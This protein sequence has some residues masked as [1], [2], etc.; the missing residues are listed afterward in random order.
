VMHLRAS[1]DQGRDRGD[2]DAVAEIAHFVTAT[3]ALASPNA[4]P[5]SDRLS[6]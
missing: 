6:L 3:P 1:R 2:A 5:G 4:A